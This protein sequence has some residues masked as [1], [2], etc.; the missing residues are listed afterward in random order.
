[1]YMYMYYT[2]CTQMDQY[3]PCDNGYVTTN[4][5]LTIKISE[6]HVH[7]IHTTVCITC[8]CT[9]DII[10]FLYHTRIYKY[11]IIL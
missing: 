6:V 3:T 8:T 1:M 10:Y 2:T 11:N 7:V 4:D 5:E 9:S